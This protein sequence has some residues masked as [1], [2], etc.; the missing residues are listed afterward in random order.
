[1]STYTVSRQP[2]F[3]TDELLGKLREWSIKDVVV[4]RDG[5]PLW[6][7]H[8][9]GGDRLGA[10]YSATKSF[11]SAL[12]GIAIDRGD[13]PSIDEPAS[14]YFPA[15]AEAADERYGRITL[16][17]LLTM[18]SGLDWPDF[19]KPY[20]QMRRCD[21]WIGFI[22]AQ[23]MAHEPGGAFAYNSGGSHLLS[24]ILA[25]VTGGTT[26]AYA[27]EMLFGKLG[28]KKPRWNSSQ[29]IHE[30]GTG[31]HLTVSDMAKFGQLY[32]QGGEWEGNRIVSQAWVR[33]STTTHHKGLQ[34]YDPPIFGTYGYHWWV[35]NAAHNGTVDCYFAEGYGGQFIFVVPTLS[36]VAAIR[37]EPEGK[38]SAM[39]AKR[40]LFEHIVPFCS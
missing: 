17:H 14:T 20:W 31:L 30:G 5:E 13:L 16:R 32:M 7:W 19:D 27:Q 35:S 37:K 1:M 38:P 39:Y 26:Y 9:K 4:L 2:S 28:F 12:I 10:V 22:L 36:L 6:I 25:Q 33:A 8:E 29:G 3:V 40:L 15:L 24:A 34:H 23:P 18:T 11:V 21:D